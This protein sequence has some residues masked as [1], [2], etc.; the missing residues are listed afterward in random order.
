M[1]GFCIATVYCVFI[2]SIHS[3][4]EG[5]WL[6]ENSKQQKGCELFL[7]FELSVLLWD[8]SSVPASNWIQIKNK[9]KHRPTM[10]FAVF[11]HAGHAMPSWVWAFVLSVA[12]FLR[13]WL[14]QKT[15]WNTSK[16]IYLSLRTKISGPLS[17]FIIYTSCLWF[18]GVLLRPFPVQFC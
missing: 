3:F 18:T 11:R 7:F 16:G 2:W 6:V 8:V 1:H 4:G 12:F 13:L 14:Q 5:H 17:L 10:W 9:L 15:Y